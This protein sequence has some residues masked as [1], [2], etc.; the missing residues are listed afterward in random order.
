MPKTQLIP[1]YKRFPWLYAVSAAAVLLFFGYYFMQQAAY[2]KAWE[3]HNVTLQDIAAQRPTEGNYTV[4]GGWLN[5]T[6]AQAVGFANDPEKDAG[7]HYDSYVPYYDPKTKQVVML[8]KIDG[9]SP[10]TLL[11][12]RDDP[13][14]PVTGYFLDPSTVDPEIYQDFANRKFSVQPNLPVLWLAG[15]PSESAL[16]AHIWIA[17]ILLFLLGSVP[18]G[19]MYLIS[20]PKKPRKRFSDRYPERRIY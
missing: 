19:V 8:V 7:S 6:F 5:Y 9:E 1:F 18:W 14:E 20:R 17:G 4:T 15:G 11:V 10:A 2:K 12:H 16:H 13:P 3:L